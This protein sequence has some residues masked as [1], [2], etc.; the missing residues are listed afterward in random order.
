MQ[1]W[2][3]IAAPRFKHLKCNML[4]LSDSLECWTLLLQFCCAGRCLMY[5]PSLAQS[6]EVK[7]RSTCSSPHIVPKGLG[8]R[9]GD[10]RQTECLVP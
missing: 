3:R 5:V 1:S 10:I 9:G 7:N 2:R 4:R 6:L 8:C